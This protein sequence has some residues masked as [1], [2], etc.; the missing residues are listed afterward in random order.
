VAL[1]GALS[2]GVYLWVLA[3]DAPRIVPAAAYDARAD[4]ANELY[5]WQDVADDVARTV[6]AVR[7]PLSEPGDVVVVGSVWMVAAQ[8]EARLPR[9]VPVGCAGDS[10]ADF[11]TWNP[12]ATW[13]RA[14]LVVF[15]HDNRMPVDGEAA[16]PDRT[17]I[18]TRTRTL[19]RGGHTARTF[20]IEVL[21]RRAAG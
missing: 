12:P 15:V 14:E 19:A 13:Q 7:P 4:I 8:L 6:E 16:F 5:G 17:R 9:S 1:A 3:P 21:S 2:A 10:V 20:T 11:S 18:A